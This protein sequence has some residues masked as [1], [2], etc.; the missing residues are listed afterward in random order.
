MSEMSGHDRG[1][2][3]LVPALRRG[4]VVTSARATLDAA[5]TEAELE[6]Q[7]RKLFVQYGF[8]YY[9]TH[10]SQFSPSGFPACH[11]IHVGQRR[12]VYVEL[13]RTPKERLSPAQEYYRD[14]LRAVGAEWYRF[15]WS[16]PLELIVRIL[17]ARPTLT[18]S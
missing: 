8:L 11:A 9:H 5:R 17:Q 13:K 6:R 2:P 1:E 12:I 7:V 16:T 14:A 4:V 18:S 3:A 10:R 15:D